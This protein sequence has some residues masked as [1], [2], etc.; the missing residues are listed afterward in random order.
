MT[1]QLGIPATTW[2]RDLVLLAKNTNVWLS[3][4]SQKYRK[5]ITRFDQIP[6]EEIAQIA[7]QE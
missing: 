5:Q 3:Q 2:A 7:S 6:D 4:L 1:K